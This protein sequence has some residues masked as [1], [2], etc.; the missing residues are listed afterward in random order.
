M[1]RI[2]GFALFAFVVATTASAHDRYLGTITVWDGGYAANM[3]L[4]DAGFLIGQ[5]AKLSIQ[6]SKDTCV[7]VDSHTMT[8]GV[9][10]CNCTTG[11]LVPAGAFFQTSC[12]PTGKKFYITESVLLSDG[13]T[14]AN[15]AGLFGPSCS[16]ACVA[17]DAGTSTCTVFER[18]G[19]EN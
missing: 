18:L 9:L 13:G 17:L 2:A 12:S 10:S 11:V 16:V 7:C 14:A 8:S 3:S 15:D 19:T 6:P 4:M 1:S 5:G